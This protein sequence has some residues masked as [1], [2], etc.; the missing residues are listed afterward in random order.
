MMPLSDIQVAILAILG[1][2]SVLA[3]TSYMAG[4]STDAMLTG[5]GGTAIAAISG[6]TGYE[7]GKR[8]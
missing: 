7:A 1:V 8:V 3:I 4:V 6:L 5:I 2:A